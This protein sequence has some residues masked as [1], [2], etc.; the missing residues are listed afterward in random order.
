MHDRRA[1]A[2]ARSVQEH[3]AGVTAPGSPKPSTSPA[4]AD[5]KRG[6]RKTAA[7]VVFFKENRGGA[8]RLPEQRARIRTSVSDVALFRGTGVACRAATPATDARNLDAIHSSI[9]E[10]NKEVAQRMGFEFRQM[11]NP[12]DLIFISNPPGNF[13]RV[14]TSRGN[15]FGKRPPAA[16]PP[17]RLVPR[18]DVEPMDLEHSPQRSKGQT[19][20]L[21]PA[22][23]SQKQ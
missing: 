5:C 21:L 1:V 22:P 18:L 7:D 20:A 19:L 4:A 12:C 11:L 15:F 17:A 8:S 13:P 10:F 2:F 3:E 9:Y 16:P 23:T 14:L 6:S